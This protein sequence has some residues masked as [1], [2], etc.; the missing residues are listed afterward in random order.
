L[1]AKGSAEEGELKRKVDSTDRIEEI[2]NMFIKY[3]YTYNV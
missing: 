2:L 3:V 1:K